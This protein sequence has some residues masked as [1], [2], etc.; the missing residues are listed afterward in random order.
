MIREQIFSFRLAPSEA[1]ALMR[2]SAHLQ[3]ERGA[4]M[5]WLIGTASEAIAGRGDDPH[6]EENGDGHAQPVTAA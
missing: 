5:R 3:R 1:E 6:I 4:V 2:L